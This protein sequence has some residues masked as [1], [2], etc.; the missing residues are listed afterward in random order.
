MN[1]VCVARLRGSLETGRIDSWWAGRGSILEE[2][3]KN[4]R[5]KK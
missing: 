1:R 2:E 4:F 5:V 3:N